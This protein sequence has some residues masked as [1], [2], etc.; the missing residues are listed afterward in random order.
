MSHS[1]AGKIALECS[2]NLMEQILLRAFPKF[3]GYVDKG[4]NTDED[5]NAVTRLKSYDYHGMNSPDPIVADA[6]K[7]GGV[8]GKIVV[9]GKARD[10]G[11]RGMFTH[12]KTGL[13]NDLTLLKMSDGSWN[14]IADPHANPSLKIDKINGVLTQTLGIMKIEAQM[15]VKGAELLKA[16]KT[17]GGI[18]EVTYVVP[19][20]GYEK[21]GFSVPPSS[22][23]GKYNV[24]NDAKTTTPKQTQMRA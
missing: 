1:V 20:E 21:S 12:D 16:A 22:P 14:I 8:V 19:T 23:S 4:V 9:H 10:K 7:K 2:V 3:A 15:K 13:C 6:E 17:V 24:K 11:G 5:K 18:T